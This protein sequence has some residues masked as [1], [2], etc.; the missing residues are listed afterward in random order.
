MII[1]WIAMALLGSSFPAMAN[2]PIPR[3]LPAAIPAQ[4][5]GKPMNGIL[6]L[7][8]RTMLGIVIGRDS[9][10]AV[11]RK[12]GGARVVKADSIEGRP[13][14]MCFVSGR[15]GTTLTVEA[16]PLGGFQI[17]TGV[18]VAPKEAFTADMHEC[19]ST[20]K[21]D[22]ASL[23]AGAL[24]LGVRF[25]EVLASL[26]AD[27]AKRDGIVELPFETSTIRKVKGQQREVDTISGVVAR[28]TDDRVAW[29]S[30]Y[31]AESM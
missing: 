25:S 2:G 21:F 18:T 22:R 14:T 16:G 12:L 11:T 9:L 29:F 6:P 10:Q 4:I 23:T 1:R 15:D 24:R 30:I 28:V 17:V 19:L 27:P 5:V 7:R 13:N 3:E 8:N 26:R 20:N 31:Y